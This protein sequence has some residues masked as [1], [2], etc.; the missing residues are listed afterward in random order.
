MSINRSDRSINDR[1]HNNSK[2]QPAVKAAA[3]EAAAVMEEKTSVGFYMQLW[4]LVIGA[5]NF[6]VICCG[7]LSG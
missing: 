6:A 1:S 3:V 5:C 4:V 2:Q 7:C